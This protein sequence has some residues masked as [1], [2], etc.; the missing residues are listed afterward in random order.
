[1]ECKEIQDNLPAYMDRELAQA[2]EESIRIHLGVCEQ[3]NAHYTKLLMGWQVLDA[4]ED[5]TPPDSLRRRILDSARPQRK[6]TSLR[7]VLS[8]AAL[9][10]LV[11]GI[12]VYYSEQMNRAMQ[13]LARNQSPLQT[14]AVNDINEDEIIANLLILQDNDFLEAL[15]ELVMIDELPLDEESFK[16][17]GGIE[18]NSVEPV[19][20]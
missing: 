13:D 19:S 11:F 17:R 15:D 10:L 6:V 14:A 3:C 5:V 2:A 20:S 9:L 4:W 1:M 16:G 7:A 12:I 18:R 8:V